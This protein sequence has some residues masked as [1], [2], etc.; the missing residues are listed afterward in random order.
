MNGHVMRRLAPAVA[1]AT[2]T[3]FAATL[4]AGYRIGPPDVSTT[5]V[6]CDKFCRP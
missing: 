3:V 5:T 6:H 4:P 1:A 2:I